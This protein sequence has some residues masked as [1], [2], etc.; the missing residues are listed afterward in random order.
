MRLSKL[1]KIWPL[2]LL[3][4]IVGL[5]FRSFIFE[6]KLPLP[7][8]TILGMYHPWRDVVWDNFTAGVPFKN[9]LIT[10]PVRQQYPWREL[11]ISLLKQGELALWNPYAFAGAPLLANFQSAPFYPLNLLFFLFPFNFAWGTLIFLEPLLAGLFLYLYL[12]NLNIGKS[13]SF[14]G[15]LTFAFSGF[16]VAWLEWG[17]ILHAGLWLPLILLSIDKIITHSNS[18]RNEKFKWGIIFVFSLIASFFAG[19][20]QTAFYVIGISI[21][22]FLV[23]WWQSGKQKKTL[24]LFSIF[25]LLF[26]IIT[27]VQW[28]PTLQFI[29]LS[30]RQIDIDWQKPGWFLPWQNLVQF[31]A[32]DFFGNPATLNYWGIWNYGEFIGYIGIVPLIFALLTTFFRKDKKTLFFGTLFFLALSFALPTPWAKIPYQLQIPL[33]ATSQPTRLLFLIDFSL[34]ILAAL[35]FDYFL[36]SVSMNQFIETSRIKEIGKVLFTLFLIIVGLWIFVIF[37]PK[38]WSH[39]FWFPNL[40]ISK[41]NLILPTL[42]FLTFVGTVILYH[43]LIYHIKFRRVLFWGRFGL[44]MGVLF[45]STFDLLRFGWK[46]TPFTKKEWLFPQTKTIEFLKNQEEPFRFMSLDRRIF[47]PNSPIVYRLQTVEGYDPLYLARYGQLVAAWESGNPEAQAA[48]GRILTPHNF[49]SKIADLLNVK[50]VLSLKEEKSPKLELVF[51]E[52]QTRVYENKKV[53]PRAFFVYDY[54]VAKSSQEALHLL[55]AEKTDLAKTAIL[56]EDPKIKLFSPQ[57]EGKVIIK[58]YRE[59]KVILET[60]SSLPG[61]LILSDNFYPGWQAF[62]DGKQVKIY[63][64][65]YTLRG[66]IVPEGKHKVEFYLAL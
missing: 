41:R 46:F 3:L 7:A 36:K 43:I 58:E 52:G 17:T 10:D 66:I 12:R 26:T 42:L 53:L 47:P 8:D 24:F 61:L 57:E 15:A 20:L 38:I 6:G 40:E 30:A 18:W 28:L 13:A 32:P 60:Q 27:A 14:L 21:V 33:I 65:D 56:E 2:V 62:I 29:N 16:S 5:F 44:I 50:Y 9:F 34:A 35:G 31:I 51:Q 22:Y 1:N 23:R 45:L 59:Q 25:Y 19:H 11:A 54:Q 49:E 63:R 37:A 39:T 4:A 64:V 48:F 55:M